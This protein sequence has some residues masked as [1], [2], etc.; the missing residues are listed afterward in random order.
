MQETLQATHDKRYQEPS[1]IPSERGGS[2][3]PKTYGQKLLKVLGDQKGY[4]YLLPAIILLAIFTFY[5][6]FRTIYISFLNGYKST[7]ASTGVSFTFGVENY[8]DVVTYSGFKEILLNTFIIVVVTVPISTILSLIIAVALNSIK[9]LRSALQTI[10][11]LPYVTNGIAI[12]MV[13]N[14]MFSFVR[15]G[16]GIVST[17][18]VFNSFLG[19]FGVD[20]IDWISAGAPK[21]NKMFVLCTYIIWNA[22][23]FKIMILLGALQ[24]VNK[25]YYDAAKIEST[26]R[27]RV[28]TKITVP[29]LSPMIAYVFTT[30]LIGAFKEYTS[31]VG[32][33]GDN[34][35]RYGMNTMVGYIYT[36]LTGSYQTGR[37]A[38]G[39]MILFAIIMVFTAIN[40]YVNKK[41]VH[42]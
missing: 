31:A 17:V 38:A 41:K 39:A 8:I 2:R 12:G 7:T 13:F 25:Q 11:F 22:L 29:L 21:L 28:F 30:S 35:R 42:Y 5:P 27:F 16:D 3:K 32:I 24:S 4:V 23:P 26:P 1:L 40:L 36:S 18:G 19:L 15:T 37:A 34:L 10:Y 14:V 33:F 20:P 9:P 6:F